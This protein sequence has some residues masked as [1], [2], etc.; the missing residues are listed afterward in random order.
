[1]ETRS[2]VFLFF[3][4]QL[5]AFLSGCARAQEPAGGQVH[6]NLRQLMRGIMFPNSN[7]IFA[8]QDKNPEDVK[9]AGDPALATDPLASTYGGWEAVQNSALALTEA[10][11]LLTIPGRTCENGR[12]VPLQNADWAQFVQGL[13]EAG[14]TAF[15]AAQSKNQDNILMAADV[16]TTACSNCHDKYREKPGGLADRCM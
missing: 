13:R 10:A 7:V 2:I 3:S 16:M 5:C 14:L 9:P 4:L 11:N 12:P 1:M 15:K 6:A 8:A